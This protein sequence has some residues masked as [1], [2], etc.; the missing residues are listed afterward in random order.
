M[1]SPG[2]KRQ[3]AAFAVAGGLCSGRAVSRYLGLSRATHRY[4]ARPP[5]EHRSR[6]VASVQALSAAHP[7]FGLRRIVALQR[8]E[9]WSVSRKQVQRMRWA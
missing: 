3:M 2:H 9:R 7:R 5:A 4:R 1:V 6:L 8:R